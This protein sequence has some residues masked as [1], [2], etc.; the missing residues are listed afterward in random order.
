MI[1]FLWNDKAAAWF[2]EPVQQEHKITTT[3]PLFEVL[4]DWGGIVV[5][6][7]FDNPELLKEGSV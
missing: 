5:G 4:E 3:K 2:C 6:T 1:Y 7:I